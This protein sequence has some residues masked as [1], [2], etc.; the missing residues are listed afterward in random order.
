MYPTPTPATLLACTV[1]AL[2]VS[3]LDSPL[4]ACADCLAAPLIF[5][6][7]LCFD[8]TSPT[9]KSRAARL[10]SHACTRAN[11][12]ILHN[13]ITIACSELTT[14]FNFQKTSRHA[15]PD[16]C[17]ARPPDRCSIHWYTCVIAFVCRLC[18][19]T[20]PFIVFCHVFVE[21]MLE[22]C[23]SLLRTLSLWC[24]CRPCR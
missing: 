9:L 14:L 23:C 17:A 1:P 19:S 3:W 20:C 21:S 13:L 15:L 4:S 5:R 24:F 11:A 22:L 12:C 16:P 10:R 6:G 18:H 8:T 7:I 2:T